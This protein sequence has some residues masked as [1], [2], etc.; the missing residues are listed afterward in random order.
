MLTGILL[1]AIVTI[2]FK[3]I[4]LITAAL[5]SWPDQWLGAALGAVLCKN[6]AKRSTQNLTVQL[7]ASLLHILSWG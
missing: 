6:K 4:F 7:N 5:R 3:Q 1:K 2:F